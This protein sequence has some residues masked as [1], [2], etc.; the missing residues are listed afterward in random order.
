M[1]VKLAKPFQW[2][3][4]ATHLENIHIY[5]MFINGARYRCRNFGA[6]QSNGRPYP[7]REED[8]KY[9]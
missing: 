5:T 3:V 4:A 9:V 8:V 6:V 2:S 1:Q 7:A